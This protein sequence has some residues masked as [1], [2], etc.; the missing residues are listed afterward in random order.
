M[1]HSTE[2]DGERSEDQRCD[3]DLRLRKRFAADRKFADEKGERRQTQNGQ[4][5][6]RQGQRCLRNA[7]ARF[8]VGER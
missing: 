3:P 2:D 8:L 1:K 5:A 6:Q 4:A 7:R